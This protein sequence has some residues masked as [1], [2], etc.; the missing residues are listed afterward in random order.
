MQVRH[1]EHDAGVAT[2]NGAFKEIERSLGEDEMRF[3][4]LFKESTFEGSKAAARKMK[5]IA[6]RET[7]H[8]QR[9]LLWQSLCVL[10]QTN[11]EMLLWPNSPLL[12]LLQF[13]DPNG[14]GGRKHHDALLLQAGKIRFTTLHT[15]AGMAD[16]TSINYSTQEN[17]LTL[18][19]Q[20]IEHGANVNTCACPGGDTPLHSACH[21]SATTNLDFIELLLKKG[22]DPN[23]QDHKGMTPLMHTNMF[24]PGSAKFLLEW[25]A[26]DVNITTSSGVSFLAKVRSTT[27]LFS[28][29]VAIPDDPDWVKNQFLLHQWREIE[30]M[31]V[32]MGADD[33]GIVD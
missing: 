24:A 33:T 21:S 2:I 11:S 1:P 9:A 26:T 19:R 15:L 6:A 5:K 29:L 18:G 31:L 16:P 32:E 17:Q 10:I 23:A 22:A 8:N 28:Q 7:K 12:V 3:F 4:K 27:A 25:A 14:L 20:L 30:E 13:V